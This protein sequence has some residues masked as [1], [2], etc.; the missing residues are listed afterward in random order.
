MFKQEKEELIEE[1]GI[2]FENLHLLPPL[3]ARIYAILLLEGMEGLTFEELLEKTASSKSSVSTNINLLMQAEMIEYTTLPGDRK[4]Y[5]RKKANHFK[6]RLN[7]YI[8]LIEKEIELNNKTQAYMKQTNPEHIEKYSAYMLIY[9]DYL[10]N[11]NAIMQ[12]SLK[13]LEKINN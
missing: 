10:E 4:R 5:F 2:H 11:T 9:K 8:S 7:K 13:K 12:K 3:A 1:L 6:S